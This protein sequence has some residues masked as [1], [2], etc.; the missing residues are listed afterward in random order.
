MEIS[1]YIHN[2]NLVV[3]V[4]PN[5]K[6]EKVIEENNQLK[7]YLK[8]QPD[9][10]KANKALIKFFKENYNLS[11]QIKSGEKSRSKVLSI[12]N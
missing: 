7:V 5:S 4:I 2:G 12:L 6:V 11:V 8:A 10:N 3:K 9:K 1:N